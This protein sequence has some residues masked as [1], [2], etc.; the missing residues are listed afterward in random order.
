MRQDIKD[1]LMEA[2]LTML[3]EHIATEEF[4]KEFSR[5][6]GR[7]IRSFEID[8]SCHVGE[9]LF[10]TSHTETEPLS[11]DPDTGSFKTEYPLSVMKAELCHSF[12]D[13]LRIHIFDKTS[14]K[15]FD[16]PRGDG[17]IKIYKILRQQF[18]NKGILA[19]A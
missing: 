7:A 15:A 19:S 6:Q 16:H 5:D 3:R 9:D 18:V 17:F 4:Q 14:Q 10:S 11:E 8:T 12:S 13:E 2:F 1:D